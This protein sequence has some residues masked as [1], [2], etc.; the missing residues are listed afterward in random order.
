M[1]NEG[2][3]QIQVICEDT[4]VFVI[5]LHH[6]HQQELSEK[7]PPVDVLMQYPPSAQTAISI[8]KTIESLSSTVVSSVLAAHVLSGCD[9]VPQLF[10]IGKKVIKLLKGPDNNA[11]GIEQLGNIDPDIPWD[12][13]STGIEILSLPVPGRDYLHPGRDQYRYR[14]ENENPAGTGISVIPA[15]TGTG[16][17]PIFLRY[18]D[19]MKKIQIKPSRTN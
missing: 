13:W 1:V 14:D 9:T 10:G 7:V 8:P 19:R 17:F 16:I 2:Y 3:R 6:Y 18:S 5:L 4:D 15:G 12:Q 11:N